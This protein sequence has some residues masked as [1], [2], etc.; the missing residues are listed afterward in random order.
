MHLLN[1][2]NANLVDI[3]DPFFDNPV[4]PAM[5]A[6]L[7]V[8]SLCI[9]FEVPMLFFTGYFQSIRT[10]LSAR[11]WVV[12]EGVVLKSEYSLD[13]DGISDP[14]W[15]YDIHYRF[16]VDNKEY[17]SQRVKAADESYGL[18]TYC[19]HITSKY[20]QCAKVKVY[21]NRDNPE[22]CCLQKNHIVSFV[23]GFLLGILLCTITP[24][25][26][27]LGLV[28]FVFGTNLL[29]VQILIFLV[30][31]LP[32][33][34]LFMWSQGKK[35]AYKELT[36]AGNAVYTFLINRNARSPKE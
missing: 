30:I 15:I 2:I 27:C 6:V 18:K 29:V 36:A 13:V 3:T 17:D 11:N 12:A 23:F 16:K 25:I 31:L 33:I 9:A 19:Q 35:I 5:F 22:E 34:F 21:Y 10:N 7:V 14:A 8:L 20:P 4:Q 28:C 24:F 32:T 1:A 26:F